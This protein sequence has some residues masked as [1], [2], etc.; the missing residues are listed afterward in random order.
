M[1]FSSFMQMAS[2]REYW[3]PPRL[4]RI[5]WSA[6]RNIHR[7]VEICQILARPEFR[8]IA[9]R[10]PVFPFKYLSTSYLFPG[11]SATERAQCFLHHYRYVQ[12]HLDCG[13]LREALQRDTVL[14]ELSQ[15]GHSSA[16]TIGPPAENALWEG[17]LALALW[18]DGEPLYS[19]QFAIVPGWVLQS[20]EKNAFVILRIQGVKGRLD[21]IRAATRVLQDIAPPA[22]LVAALAG[23][24]KAWDIRLLGGISALSQFSREHCSA[25]LMRTYDEFFATLGATQV[26]DNFFATAIP[27]KEK[28]IDEI[29]NGHKAR[30]RKK[31]LFKAMVTEEVCRR[32]TEGSLSSS[33]SIEILNPAESTSLASEKQMA[34]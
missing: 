8:S 26:S 15:V 12:D 10:H 11:L 33:P 23:I 18:F 34:G 14:L 9:S 22:L 21:E 3:Y 16:V 2:Q 6:T 20:Q 29:T 24:A 25:A 4:A 32:I 30:T 1:Y 17:E 19:L 27:L 13:I 28:A 7:Q 5:L 31:R